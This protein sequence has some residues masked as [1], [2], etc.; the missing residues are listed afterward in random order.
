M[1]SDLYAANPGNKET[2][3]G[4]LT[5]DIIRFFAVDIVLLLLLRLLSWWG[6]FTTPD[7]YVAAMLLSKLVLFCY[8]VWIIRDRREAWPETG[9]TSAGRWW[10]W[11]LA[12]ALYAGYYQM[13]PLVGNINH[14]LMVRLHQWAGW[15][16]V[17]EPQDVMLYIFA[18]VLGGPMR[19]VLVFFTI[20][21]GPIMEELAFR[22]VGY[23]AYRRTIG[24]GGALVWTSLLFGLYH[25]RLDLIIP[26]GLL[27]LL[28]GAVRAFSRTLWCPVFLHCLHN[29][30][31]LWAMAR[32]LGLFK[33]MN[34]G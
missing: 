4:F 12:A 5:R 33:T 13:I 15:V 29:G 22:G 31:A 3:T 24:T 30:V 8:L 19:V 14:I 34:W 28:F 17:P 9:A 7:V 27:G 23:D 6:L 10:A 2:P 16:Y 18:D 20:I 1:L 26:L 32:E 11:P 25:F 21:A